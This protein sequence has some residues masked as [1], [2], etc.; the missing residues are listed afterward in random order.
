MG[1]KETLKKVNKLFGAGNSI[2]GKKLSPAEVELNSY[3]ERERQD[4]IKKKLFHYR[5]Q[6]SNEILMGHK[7]EGGSTV[8]SSKNV[9]NHKNNIRNKKILDGRNSM[10]R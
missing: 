4:N 5:K 6:N 8:L 9:F 3:L 10:L 7:M 2:Q 1:I